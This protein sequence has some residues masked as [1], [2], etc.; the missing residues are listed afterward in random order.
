M[1]KEQGIAYAAITL[2]L[3]YKMKEKI[4]PEILADQMNLIYDLY[5]LDEIEAEYENYK[6]SNKTIFRRNKG[7]V[8]SYIINLYDSSK[9]QIKNV[10][11]FC[12]KHRLNLGRIYITKP[13]LNSEKY[14][15]LIRDIRN[16]EIDVL[17]ITI[18]TL[19]GMSVEEY[20]VLVKICRINNVNIIEV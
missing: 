12:F 6:K 15:E 2:D 14:Y 7:K 9:D 11:K 18:F 17:V 4:S 8:G 5:D 16:R 19:M 13:G 1:N 3:L 20:A 10:E